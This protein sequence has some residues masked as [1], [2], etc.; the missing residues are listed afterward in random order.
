MQIGERRHHE[1]VHPSQQM[2]LRDAIP[3]P[4]L[5]EQPALVAPLSPVIALFAVDSVNRGDGA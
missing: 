5:V 2:A 3:D 1:H 4:E